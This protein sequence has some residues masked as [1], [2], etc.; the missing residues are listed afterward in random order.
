MFAEATYRRCMTYSLDNA[1]AERP[2]NGAVAM[3]RSGY[4]TGYELNPIQRAAALATRSQ[5]RDVIVTAIDADGSID[6]VDLESNEGSRVWHY[7][8]TGLS[9]GEPVSIHDRYSVL[10]A[11]RALFS[12]RVA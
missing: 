3:M 7:T 6:L 4:E 1:S 5:W 12:V 11:G 2:S 8:G 9:V 10:A